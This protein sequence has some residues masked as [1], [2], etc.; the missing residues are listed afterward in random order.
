MILFEMLVIAFLIVLA[1]TYGG[2][3]A[4]T[5]G[6]V[7]VVFDI[8]PLWML[9]GAFVLWFVWEYRGVVRDEESEKLAE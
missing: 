4:L 3:M 6:V 2:A 8:T 9:A 7:Y 5:F 1:I